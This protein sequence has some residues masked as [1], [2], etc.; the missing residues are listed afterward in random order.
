MV[1]A[2]CDDTTSWP[3][4]FAL[5][6][7]LAGSSFRPPMAADVG[8]WIKP[9][10]RRAF[11]DGTFIAVD[12]TLLGQAKK[13]TEEGVHGKPAQVE[14]PVPPPAPR[15]PVTPPKTL[16]SFAIRLVDELGTAISGVDLQFSHGGS[17][18]DG[19]TDGNGVA[20]VEDSA[21]TSAKAKIVDAKALRKA[22]K[23]RWDQVR[24][25]RKW[26]DESQ[27][28]TVVRLVGDRLPSF[29]LLAEKLRIVSVQPFVA[30]VRLIGGFFDTS[31]CFVLPRGLDAVRA[32]VKMYEEF[33]KAK[34]LAAGHT[35]TA[36]KPAYNDPLSLERAEAVKDYLTDNVDG[37]YK[38]YDASQPTEKRWG[39]KE[40][41]AMIVTLPGASERDPRE[42]PVRWFQRTRGLAVDGIA[43]TQTRHALIREYMSLDGTSLP[44]G[45]EVIPHGCGENFPAKATGEDAPAEENRRVELF[46]FDGE[47]G[48]EPPPAGK[49]SKA[50][51]PRYPEWVKRTK[52]TDD[53]VIVA[54][55]AWFQ[56]KRL[57][58]DQPAAGSI[59]VIELPDGTVIQQKA[60][61]KGFI[62]LDGMTGEKFRLVEIVDDERGLRVASIDTPTPIA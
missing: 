55:Q 56:L 49:N 52:R 58:D 28:V 30:R 15:R 11:E 50:G 1:D 42:E 36:G 14:P 47:L 60:D 54:G 10:L 32:V 44:K 6:E 4:M 9:R 19:S 46:F 31:K 53:H 22:V 16:H 37:W 35:D 20:R 18:D 40:D 25:D 48:V 17:Q 57:L 7:E 23:P 39:A 51:S 41:N 62:R 12:A 45:I 59:A 3:E 29:D 34:L 13:S 24:G 2:W 5:Y 27:G 61:E 43:G 8:E 33:P 26:L 21:A 38:W